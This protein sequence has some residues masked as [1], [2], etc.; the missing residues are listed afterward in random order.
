MYLEILMTLAGFILMI[1]GGDQLVHGALKLGQRFGL[2][3][4]FMGLTIVAF[5]TSA[6]ELFTTIL[7][8]LKGQNDIALANIMGSNI[9][10]IAL[11]LG[12]IGLIQPIFVS[13]KEIRTELALVIGVSLFI[14]GSGVFGSIT[15][16]HGLFLIGVYIVFVYFRT[17]QES[18]KEESFQDK[19]ISLLKSSLRVLVGISLL[20]VGAHFSLNGSIQIGRSLG[21]E[22]RLIGAFIISIGTSLPELVTSS[23]A[24]FQN[25]AEM[26][27]SNIIGSNLLNS[28]LVLG[29]ASFFNTISVS[30]DVLKMD[31][32]FNALASLLVLVF[33]FVFKNKITRAQGGLWIFIYFCYAGLSFGIF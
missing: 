18:Q 32:S 15:L 14:W 25:K 5:G 6:P 27:L 9:F 1:F 30:P 17:R 20:G 26:A 24:A 12:F 21:W 28:I 11:V 23:L 29:S 2:S 22:E 4:A 10:N 8:Q 7:A 13:I 33:L 16:F 3:Q 31:L 19:S